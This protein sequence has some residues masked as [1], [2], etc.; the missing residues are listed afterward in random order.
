MPKVRLS[1]MEE[2]ARLVQGLIS[3]NQTML[4]LS[5]EEVAKKIALSKR[6]YQN[7]KNRPDTFKLCELWRTC[8]VLKFTEEEKKQ[9][10]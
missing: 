10:L 4:K 3:K 1:E 2:K 5:D 7:K 8:K 9:V 6:T